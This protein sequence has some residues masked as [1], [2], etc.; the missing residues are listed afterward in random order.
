MMGIKTSLQGTSLSTATASL[1]ITNMHWGRIGYYTNNL[2]YFSA[3]T[4][5]N[6]A[7]CLLAN[8]KGCLF[9]NTA[10]LSRRTNG[11]T[12]GTQMGPITPLRQNQVNIFYNYAGIP[13][14]TSNVYIS[15]AY[16]MHIRK[17]TFRLELLASC[18][19]CIVYVSYVDNQMH[20]DYM[21]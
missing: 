6:I 9:N 5:V 19:I 1:C 15:N 13:V 20:S 8:S 16:L 11:K 3:T 17:Y 10:C 12:W 2:K 7:Y 21:H 18:A 4:S 14:T